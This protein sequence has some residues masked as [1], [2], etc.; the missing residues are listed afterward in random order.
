MP[1][2]IDYEMVLEQMRSQKFRC[3]YYNSGAFGFP[4]PA[5]VRTLA[6]IGPDDATP[7]WAERDSAYRTAA[8]TDTSAAQ[9]SI[10]A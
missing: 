1:W 10:E 9:I 4:D 5:A 2:I 3:H 6:W 7:R 8:G